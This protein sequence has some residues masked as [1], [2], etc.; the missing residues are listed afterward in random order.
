[1][2]A[3]RLSVYN[4]ALSICGE[5]SLSLTSGLTEVREGRY[6]LD[7][8][9]NNN[10]VR[11]CLEQAQWK[12]AMRSQMLDYDTSI[13][14][15]FGYRR[16][17]QK[18]TDWCLTSAVCSDEYFR[19]PLLEYNDEAGYLYSNIDQIYVRFVSDDS[20]YGGDMSLWTTTFATYVAS[21]FASRVIM[22]LSSD[23]ERQKQVIGLSEKALKEA[24]SLDAMADPEK[25]IPHGSWASSRIRGIRRDRG[26]RSNLIG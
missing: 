10:G 13:T 6:L 22:T 26:S 4:E 7:D 23:K 18:G 2:S 24:K 9:W 3:T 17:F 20:S 14:P 16:A 5:R 12:F 8:V 21:H 1:M 15:G 11:F 19:T 25:M